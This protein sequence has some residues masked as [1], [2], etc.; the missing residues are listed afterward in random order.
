MKSIVFRCLFAILFL[1]A[2]VAALPAHGS[3]LT[4][5]NQ[6]TTMT[7]D[8]ASQAGVSQWSVDGVNQLAQQWFWYRI[9][10]VGGESSIDTLSAASGGT[11]SAN[12]ATISYAGS[13]GLMVSIATFVTGG[14]N[15]SGASGWQETLTVSNTSSQSMDLHFFQYADF[16]LQGTPGG[17][18]VNFDNSN[19]VLQSKITGGT[20]STVAETGVTPTP[21]HHEGNFFNNTLA[22]LNNASPTTLSDLPGLNTLFGPGDV[23]WAYEWDRTLSPGGSFQISKPMSINVTPVPEPSTLALL[24][25]GAACLS[26]RARRGL[27][28]RQGAGNNTIPPGR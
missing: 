22:S 6:N 9:G 23:T 25:F 17:D 16:D 20:V 15:G 13:N 14:A 18:T 12:A 3:I 1:V 7:I 26:V 28:S 19:D 11:T 5:T 10:S 24:G 21:N 4:L 2:I 27:W 8:T